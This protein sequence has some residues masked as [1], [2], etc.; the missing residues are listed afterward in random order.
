MASFVGS[1]EEFK[2]YLGPRMRNLFNQLTRTYKGNIGSCQHCGQESNLEAAHRHGNERN[3]II[4]NILEESSHQ[5]VATINLDVFEEKYRE[6]HQP[7]DETILILCKNCHREYDNQ[8]NYAAVQTATT[9]IEEQVEQ[10]QQTN[11]HNGLL[12]IT[13]EPSDPAQ[14]KE[15]L[16]ESRKADIYI[17][18]NDGRQ[19]VKRWNA[20]RFSQSSDVL[21]NLRSRAEFRQGNWQNRGIQSVHVAVRLT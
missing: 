15:A 17:R 7:L 8:Q 12:P 18:Y 10:Q 13:L 20:N 3:Q 5:G 2:R 19:E 14:F 1:T 21:N 4:E 9:A 16:L 6:A 11:G